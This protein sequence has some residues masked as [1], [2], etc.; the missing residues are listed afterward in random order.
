MMLIS[1]D[2]QDILS[3]MCDTQAMPIKRGVSD[4]ARRLSET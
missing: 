2:E 3:Q 4:V 1:L